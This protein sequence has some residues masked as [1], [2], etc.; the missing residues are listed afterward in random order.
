MIDIGMGIAICGLSFGASML[1]I[2]V[3]KSHSRKNGKNNVE[4]RT[5]IARRETLTEDIKGVD[6]KLDLIIKLLRSEKK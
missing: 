6:E 3:V 4:E 1:G 5:C 2:T